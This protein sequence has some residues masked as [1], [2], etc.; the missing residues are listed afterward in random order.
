MF[1]AANS[2]D[3]A[4]SSWLIGAKQCYNSYGVKKSDTC[5]ET[6]ISENSFKLFFSDLSKNCTE[7]FF[8][9][10][11]RN[12]SNCFACTNLRNKKYCFLNEQLTKEEYERKVSEINLGDR[13][14][15][16]KWQNRFSEIKRK[17]IHKANHNERSTNISGDWIT[18]SRNCLQCMFVHDSENV[19]YS[20]GV[21]GI[22]DSYDTISYGSSEL[23]YDAF[24]I[25]M[26]NTK[27][28][29]DVNNVRDCEYCDLCKNCNNCFGCIGLINKSFCIFNKQYTEEEYWKKLDEIKTTMLERGEYGEFFPPEMSPVPYVMSVALS[30]AGFEDIESAAQYGYDVEDVEPN[31]ASGDDVM[32]ASD[33]PIDIKDV[34]NDILTKVI[35][36]EKSGKKFRYTKS[37][38]DFHRRYNLALPTEYYMS[39]LERKRYELGPISFGY[40]FRLCAGCGEE[41]QTS[42]PED[43]PSAPEKV[44]CE[45]CY[46]REVV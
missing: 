28:S 2:E 4:Y 22:R 12:C 7:S 42:I 3:S 17:A 5:Y 23:V 8:L 46:N 1:D 38:L 27:F 15:V 24:G 41:T 26:Y 44:Y 30:F 33:V 19:A 11:C 29:I 32:L 35:L 6:A 31:I 9:Y 14:V 40:R 20:L 25:S 13:N 39:G 45:Q 34:G 10:D 43:Y 21:T 37:E 36:D 18:N 16:A